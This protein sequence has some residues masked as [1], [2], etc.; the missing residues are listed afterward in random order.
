MKQPTLQSR[1]HE[2]LEFWPGLSRIFSKHGIDLCHDAESSLDDI[3][4]SRQ[5]DSQRLFTELAEAATPQ[6][7]ELGA[8]WTSA[9]LSELLRHIETV[10]HAFYERELPR[11]TGLIEK[12]VQVY[13]SDRPELRE[14]EEA[15]RNFC[16]HFIRHLDR[17]EKELF[18]AIRRL[19]RGQPNPASFPGIAKSIN[20]LEHDHEL[21]DHEFHRIRDLTG[22]FVAP[23]DACETYRAMLEGLWELEMNLHQNVYEED[24]FLFPRAIRHEAVQGSH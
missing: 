11:L 17:E 9:P 23:S 2:W 4:H 12:V 16:G 15:F 8:D 10:H 1:V 13:A 22:G 5:L 24:E 3:C 19:D 6:R 20:S 7:C 14:L 18:P 21:A